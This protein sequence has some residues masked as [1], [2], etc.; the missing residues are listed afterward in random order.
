[1]NENYTTANNIALFMNYYVVE[2]LV[3]IAF[4]L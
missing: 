1:M 4:L 3:E 2:I